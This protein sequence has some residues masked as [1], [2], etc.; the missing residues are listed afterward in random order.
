GFDNMSP[1]NGLGF[2]Y[3]STD[4]G[5]HLT[6]LGGVATD[7]TTDGIDNNNDGIVDDASETINN[8]GLDNDN[9][10]MV[11]EGDE[12]APIGS[13]GPVTAMAYGGR[14][15]GMDN[16]D[17]IYVASGSTLRLRTAIVAGD[18]TD[19]TILSAYPGDSIRD[20]VL[21]PENWRTAYVID[22]NE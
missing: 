6:A 14:L 3:E 19:F 22:S 20:I 4:Q 17:V 9:D 8:D 13:I 10:G 12:F 15:S 21:D 2:L 7:L 11:D 5:F 18:L 1:T 16:P